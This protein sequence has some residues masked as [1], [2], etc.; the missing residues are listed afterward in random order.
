M[1]FIAC[2]SLKVHTAHGQIEIRQPGDPVPEAE[3]WPNPNAWIKRGYIRYVGEGVPPVG[4]E[5]AKH[6]PPRAVT[7]DDLRARGL[8]VPA[9]LENAK[10]AP[11]AAP[12][13]KEPAEI[14]SLDEESL[15]GMKKNELLRLAEELGLG[16]THHSSKDDIIAAILDFQAGQPGGESGDD[17]EAGAEDAE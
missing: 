7:A 14:A 3:G 10:S 1:S 16:L 4:V 17:E 2:R 6:R 12:A 15:Q 11:V 8:P 9:H 5:R 13:A